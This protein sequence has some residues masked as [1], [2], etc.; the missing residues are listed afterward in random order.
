M[1]PDCVG[2]AKA[3]YRRPRVEDVGG[4]LRDALSGA[5]T[6]FPRHHMAL[7]QPLV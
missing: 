7:A 2:V 1:V 3:A 5:G 4:P 6:G